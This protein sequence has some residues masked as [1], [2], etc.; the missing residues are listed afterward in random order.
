MAVDF[1]VAEAELGKDGAV[2]LALKGGLT[3][4]IEFLVREAPGTAGQ[5]VA[6]A[7]AVGNSWTAPQYSAHS[8]SE[9]CFNDRTSPNAILASSNCA[10]SAPTSAKVRIQFCTMRCSSAKFA[11]RAAAVA[12]RGS[13]AR[14]ARRIARK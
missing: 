1:V 3:E 4:R 7:V 14:S 13:S 10:S 6:A 11:R 12:K 9:S 2:V 8:I 5:T